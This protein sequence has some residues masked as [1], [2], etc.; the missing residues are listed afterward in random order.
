[1]FAQVCVHLCVNECVRITFVSPDKSKR[2]PL[3]VRVIS[4]MR[5]CVYVPD[6]AYLH[7]SFTAIQII[8]SPPGLQHGFWPRSFVPA[9]GFAQNSSDFI[10]HGTPLDFCSHRTLHHHSLR[11]E[12]ETEWK[13]GSGFKKTPIRMGYPIGW[14]AQHR[15]FCPTFRYK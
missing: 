5:L 13:M 9:A 2:S 10:M 1:M 14:L 7:L 11:R 4:C 6:Q 3:F 12:A 15:A 8:Y